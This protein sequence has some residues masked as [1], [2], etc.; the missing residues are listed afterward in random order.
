MRKRKPMLPIGDGEEL[1]VFSTRLKAKHLRWLKTEA[2]ACDT[3]IQAVLEE[4]I[5]DE[6]K[7]LEEKLFNGK[8]NS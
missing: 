6:I 5:E 2:L 3:S 4:I 1:E 7:R 8:S